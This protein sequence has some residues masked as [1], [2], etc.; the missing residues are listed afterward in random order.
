MYK[1]FLIEH[2]ILDEA[3]YLIKNILKTAK[4]ILDSL[5]V[6]DNY[7][8]EYTNLILNRDA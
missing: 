2:G 3:K 8:Y 5:K 7:L 1:K 6:D 4:D